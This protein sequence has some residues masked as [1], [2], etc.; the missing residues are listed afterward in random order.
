MKQYV[1]Q[2]DYI[3]S[4]C[5][6]PNKIVFDNELFYNPTL[7]PTIFTNLLVF[8]TSGS[9]TISHY[10]NVDNVYFKSA[11][12]IKMGQTRPPFVLFSFFHMTNIAQIL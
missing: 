3:I 9:S 12:F 5:F 11:F 4:E 7:L 10:I 6:D 2:Q 8:N 1:I